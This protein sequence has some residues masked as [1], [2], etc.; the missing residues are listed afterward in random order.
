MEAHNPTPHPDLQ[1]IGSGLAGLVAANRAADAG[2]SVRLIERSPTLGG[3][4]T[5]ADHQGYTL[6]LGPHALY[7]NAD[8]HRALLD[9]GLDAPGVAPELAGATGAIGEGTGLLPIG[10]TALLRTRL[11][12]AGAKRQFAT[13]MARL[14]R[15]DPA[16]FATV[17]VNRWLDGLTDRPDLR[18][19]FNGLVN[20][21]TYNAAADLA[22]ADV[23]VAR[24]QHKVDVRYVAGGWASITAALADRADRV[25]VERVVARATAVEVDPRVGGSPDGPTVPDPTIVTADGARLVGRSCLIAAGTPATVDGLL[26]LTDHHTDL[27]GPP[28]EASVLDFGLRRRPPVGAHLGLDT[29][30]YATVHSVTPGLAPA[31]RHLVTAARYRW[32]GDQTGPDETRSLLADH[33]QQM[34]VD[35]ADIEMDRYLHRM[36]VTHGMPTAEGGG[37]GGRPPVEVADR[38][39]VFVAGD[40]VGPRGLLA[41]AA[42][43]SATDAVTAIGHYLDARRSARLVAS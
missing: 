11:L 37:L 13:I 22:S 25:G 39:G 5:S 26:G 40:W 2:L 18:A 36:V 14:P 7:V 20:L 33:V 43:A 17:T 6:N 15:A 16:D 1:I 8:L 21:A 10:A 30:L 31:G 28:V 29:G 27:A 32:P 42:A 12:S 19:L 9:F 3:R 34:G 38:P 4:G 41:D 24:L 35:P 23:A